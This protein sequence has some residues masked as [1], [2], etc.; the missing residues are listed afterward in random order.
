[1]HIRIAKNLVELVPDSPEEKAKLRTVW[2]LLVDCNQGTRRL[3]P[4]GEFVAARE[5]GAT[6]AVEGPGADRL[7]EFPDIVVEEDCRVY[8]D[9]CNKIQDLKKGERIPPCCGKLMEIMD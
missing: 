6:F 3:V 1:M 2:R 8:C 9:T 5:H 7:P 4:V